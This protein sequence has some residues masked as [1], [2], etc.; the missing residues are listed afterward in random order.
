MSDPHADYLGALI[1]TRFEV[2]AKPCPV[3]ATTGVY[4]WWFDSLP[5]TDM[6][7]SN[8]YRREGLTLLYAGIS[9]SKPPTNGKPPSRQTIRSRIRYHYRGNAAGSTL[10]L[11]LGS[12]LSDDLGIQ[13]RRVGSGNRLHFHEGEWLLDEWM[14]AHAFVSWVA[15][16]QPWILE[17]DL[18]A[19]LDLP[20]NLMGNSRNTYHARL[21]RARSH[22]RL[23]AFEL[24]VLPNV[25]K[26]P[27]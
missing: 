27:S 1:Q 19:K 25:G 7:T 17:D 22:S 2:L 11:T 9:P 10:R 24:P 12:L 21:S 15:H 8:C 23:R 3:P 13:L 4:G 20:L 6:D 14:S 26:R 18:I 5:A 16:P